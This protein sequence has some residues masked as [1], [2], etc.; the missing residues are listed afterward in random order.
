MTSLQKAVE[1]F[2]RA[3]E[4]YVRKFAAHKLAVFRENRAYDDGPGWWDIPSQRRRI[5]CNVV[6]GE[7]GG[8]PVYEEDGRPAN[9]AIDKLRI[10]HNTVVP[11]DERDADNLRLVSHRPSRRRKG[12]A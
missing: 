7:P 4:A 12:R 11:C 3:C 8:I 2:G 10:A 5:T 1:K 6:V 9:V